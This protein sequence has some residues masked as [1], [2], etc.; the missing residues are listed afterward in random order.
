MKLETPGA[1]YERM[2]C[3]ESQMKL[4]SGRYFDLANPRPHQFTLQ[5]IAGALAR[6]CR[7]GGHC[8]EF[9]SVAEHSYHCA[10]QAQVDGLPLG[11]VRACLL[12]DAAEAFCG[13]VI[14]PLKAMLRKD[15]AGSYGAIYR[16]VERCIEEKYLN[17]LVR[18]KE[19]AIAEI[20]AAVLFA[21]RRAM[22]KPDDVKWGGEDQVRKIEPAFRMW[23]WRDAEYAFMR[24]ACDL[25]LED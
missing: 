5:D 9:Y 4:L 19:A 23:D 3:L 22:M 16:G 1:T 13:D 14:R 10:T 8:R 21:E 25:G 12:H 7:Y 17:G 20:D 2:G 6:L 24:M 11:A 15:G 18:F